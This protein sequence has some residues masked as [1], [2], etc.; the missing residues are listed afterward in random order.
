M[1]HCRPN[2]TGTVPAHSDECPSYD[3]KRCRLLGLRPAGICEPAVEDVCAALEAA[4]PWVARSAADGRA[5]P[6]DAVGARNDLAKVQAAL[7]QAKGDA[8]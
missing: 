4:L 7:A 6:K 1:T 8:R 2:W 3:G 5:T